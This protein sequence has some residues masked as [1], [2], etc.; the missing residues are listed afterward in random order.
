[1]E[2]GWGSYSVNGV[3]TILMGEMI[4]NNYHFHNF[5][6]SST[7][8]NGTFNEI[9]CNE[10]N[11]YKTNRTF[12]RINGLQLYYKNW[13]KANGTS[14]GLLTFVYIFSILI[15]ILNPLNVCENWY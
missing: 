1:M 13:N 6:R 9:Q 11:C 14:M 10:Q 7:R 2:T 3:M 8:C 15:P 4:N 5:L 12:N